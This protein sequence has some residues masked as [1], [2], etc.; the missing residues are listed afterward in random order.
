MSDLKITV[1]AELTRKFYVQ[2]AKDKLNL[3][4]C[5]CNDASTDNTAELL[6]EWEQKFNDN[7]IKVRMFTN[8][9]GQ[10]KGV[11][12]AK[13]QAV[14]VSTGNYLCFQDIDDI[15]LPNRV[16]SQYTLAEQVPKNTLIGS[17]FQREPEDSTIRY[18]KWANSLTDKQLNE[19]IYTS[20]GPTVIMPTWFCHREIFEKI[21]GFNEEGK[22]TPEDLIFFYEHINN[23]GRVARV[24]ETL[25]IYRYHEEAT[26]FS[27]K[28][29][30]IWN[31]RMRQ[32]EK[33]VLNK[34]NA[35]TIWNA[36]KQGRKFYNCLNK[37]NKDKVIA[38]CDVD[39]KK[40]KRKY[41]PYDPILRKAGKTVDIVHFKEAKPPF[42]I[43]MKQDLTKGVFEDNLKSLNL[44]E[45][46][47]YI[48]FS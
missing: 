42:I 9:S 25:L 6:S 41:C 15:M 35:F 19:Q 16:L 31:V 17:K 44:I 10:P 7:H 26:T 40:I 2:T 12:Y 20:H 34:W 24:D 33:N 48:F 4:V 43:C 11:G 47:D 22:G 32:L 3:E 45:N 18:T 30:T 39:V 38:F 8:T 21:G 29:E 36:G 23:D 28:E 5:I 1:E 46:T 13:N 14:G 27:I 37:S